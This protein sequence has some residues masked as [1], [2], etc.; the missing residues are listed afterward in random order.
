MIKMLK[1]GNR[2]IKNFT[3]MSQLVQPRGEGIGLSARQNLSWWNNDFLVCHTKIFPAWGSINCK[4]FFNT[5]VCLAD[6][7]KYYCS[8]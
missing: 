3:L 5:K 1:L 4:D 6:F 8:G 7:Y 2:D